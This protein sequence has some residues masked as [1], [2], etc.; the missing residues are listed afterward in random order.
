MKNKKRI[1]KD[2]LDY[3]ENHL[4]GMVEDH[5]EAW[6]DRYYRKRLSD[7]RYDLELNHDISAEI[8]AVEDGLGREINDEEKNYMEEQFISQVL[9]DYYI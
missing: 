5:L 9:A 8:S 4:E 2:L 3:L 1:G 6:K 7:V